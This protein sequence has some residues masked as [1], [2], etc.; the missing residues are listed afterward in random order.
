MRCIQ[1]II[2]KGKL[3]ET[4]NICSGEG[5]KKIEYIR[6]VEKIIGKQARIKIVKDDDKSVMVGDNTKIK[7]LGW[8]RKYSLSQ[9]IKDMIKKQNS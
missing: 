1:K 8:R 7:N 9:T 4:Y 2:K 3:G 6:M 5:I